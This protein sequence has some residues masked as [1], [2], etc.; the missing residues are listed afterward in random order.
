MAEAATQPRILHVTTSP[1]IRYGETVPSV[2]LSVSIALV[3][4]LIASIVFFGMRALVLTITCVAACLLTEW[5]ITRFLLKKRETLTDFS[6]LITAL[7]LAFNLPPDL[8]PWMAVIGSIVA[9]G[10]AKWA[11]G[12]LG[13]NFINPALAG[14]AFL[15][16]SYPAA[17]TTFSA[18]KIG[19]INGLTAASPVDGV[20]GATPLVAIRD[21][22]ATGQFQALDFQE[23]L[24]SLFVGNVG[25][26]IGE[27][28]AAALLLGA[29][30]LWYKRII[31]FRIPFYYVA[32]V[33]VLS[34]LFN[35]TGGHFTSE[36]LIVPVYHILAGGLMLGALYMATDMVTSPITPSGRV[37]FGVGCGVLTFVIR[38]FG[39][40]PEG[41]SYSILL[42][43]LVVPHLNRYTRPKVYGK[44]QQRD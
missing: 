41:V 42:M 21:A 3:P 36:A 27:T 44:V 14:R 25:G 4:A 8:P 7:L 5:L 2:M 17:M 43:N 1:H 10:V 30:F 39:G 32:T 33:F 35:G 37:L 12:G 40:Y 31:G 11:F 20:T 13:H 24:S 18:P 28:S 38:K 22:V 15:T 34:W 6:A 16:A 9:I 19:N 29:L 23:A 26:C